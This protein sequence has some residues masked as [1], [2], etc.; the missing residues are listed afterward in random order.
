MPGLAGA[1]LGR[2]KTRWMH[3]AWVLR[4][5]MLLTALSLAA[6]ALREFG[7]AWSAFWRL[8]SGYTGGTIFVLAAPAVLAGTPRERRGVV[9][10]AIFAG[11]G[12]G[13]VASGTLVPFLLDAGGPLAVWIGLGVLA[14]LLSL[15]AW[16][17]WPGRPAV[18]EGASAAPAKE[19]IGPPV[20]A[21][22]AEYALNAVGLVPHMIFFVVFIT[23]GLGRGL[24]FGATCWILYGVGATVGPMLTGRL[25]DRIGFGPA[26]RL[27]L[28][29][30]IASVAL[31][32]VSTGAL[33]LMASGLVA[34]A[35]T[36]GVVG[37]VLGRIHELLH[38]HATQGRAWGYATTAFAVGQAVAAYGYTYLF[39]VVGS[40]RLL[41]GLGASALAAAL[42]LDLLMMVASAS[43]RA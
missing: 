27:A 43:R 35:L 26:L 33:P 41:F 11:V 42:V 15:A 31:P 4:A 39:D 18:T 17:G 29:A 40:Y 32:T 25:A 16:S 21:L 23:H 1:L 6:C 38:H 7:F 14:A 20:A 37:L 28:A 19:R 30:Q 5:M 13:I 2:M 3:P 10:G 36:L 24:E 22:F 8:V 12:L 34:G 9:S